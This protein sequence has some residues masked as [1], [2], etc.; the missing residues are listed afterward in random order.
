MTYNLAILTRPERVRNIVDPPLLPDEPMCETKSE[1]R[2]RLQREAERRRA[3]A[4]A[5]QMIY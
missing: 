4:R 3:R 5:A 2:R 1:R